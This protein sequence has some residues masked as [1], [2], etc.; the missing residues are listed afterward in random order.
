MVRTKNS[1][2]L[3]RPFDDHHDVLCDDEVLWN[4]QKEL[5]DDGQKVGCQR[6]VKNPFKAIVPNPCPEVRGLRKLALRSSCVEVHYL[7]M[8]ITS[9]HCQHQ[10]IT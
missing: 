4:D 8:L 10:S 3:R 2:G 7:E 6:N 9:K 5:C 1:A